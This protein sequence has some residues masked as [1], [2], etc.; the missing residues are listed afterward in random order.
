MS[1]RYFSICQFWGRLL[2]VMGGDSCAFLVA[3]TPKK[4]Q[5]YKNNIQSSK[6]RIIVC[7]MTEV[8][9]A[10]TNS[11]HGHFVVLKLPI[12]RWCIQSE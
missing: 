3:P 8:A 9:F 1:L 5:S 11:N 4:K 7:C 12:Y 6:L 2:G 10:P